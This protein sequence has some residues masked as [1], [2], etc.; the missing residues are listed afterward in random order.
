MEGKHNVI[1]TPGSMALSTADVR[2]RT[3]DV[4]TIICHNN[5]AR[6]NFLFINSSSSTA[7]AQHSNLAEV[8]AH[9]ENVLV[10]SFHENS[11]G[12]A[13]VLLESRYFSNIK[14]SVTITGKW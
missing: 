12:H 2:C 4:T 6:A 11:F 3:R 1:L 13:A 5:C 9:K 14:G 8:C 7:S 10:L